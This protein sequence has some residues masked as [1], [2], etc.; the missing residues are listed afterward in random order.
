MYL[1][2]KMYHTGAVRVGPGRI[3]GRGEHMRAVRNASPDVEI[4]EVDE[5]EGE[6][7]LLRVVTAGI[8]ASDLLYL[9]YGSREIAG[10]EFAGVLDDGTAVAVEPIFGCA[11]CPQCGLGA[12]DGVEDV[13]LEVRHPHQ[14]EAR[15]RIGAVAPSGHYD[16]VLETGLSRCPRPIQGRLPR[17]RRALTPT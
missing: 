9:Q 10:H 16:V 12:G 2:N 17:R 14:F 11:S 3:P 4:V 7:E 1:R 5:P 6:G 8:C 15:H 13:A